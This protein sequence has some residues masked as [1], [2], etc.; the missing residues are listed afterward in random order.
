MTE[1]PSNTNAEQA[2]LLLTAVE[3][4]GFRG[5]RN[6]ELRGLE[7]INFLVGTG[8]SGKTS[9]LEA[10]AC[11]SHPL[12]VRE[13][14]RTS[15][16]REARENRFFATHAIDALRWM[17][18]HEISTDGDE[19]YGD[20]SVVI[21]GAS[22]IK[23]LRAHCEPYSGLRRAEAMTGIDYE[24][25]AELANASVVEDDGWHFKLESLLRGANSWES[26]ELVAWSAG[27]TTLPQATGST[28]NCQLIAP[29]AHR[30]Q[31]AQ[32]RAL[33]DV[34]VNDQKLAVA[35]LLHDLDPNIVGIEIISEGSSGRAQLALRHKHSGIAP[36]HV[37]GDGLRRALMIA[38]A[39][40]QCR[41]GVMLIDEIEAALH[42]SALGKVFP[43]LERACIEHDVQLI[44]TTHSLE[45]IDAVAGSIDND[46]V[47]AFHI[48]GHLGNAKRYSKDMLRRLVHERGLDIR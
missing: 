31:P 28:L 29:Y 30:N 21:E 47:A 17:F 34:T 6:L 1:S 38:L 26:L 46:H 44:G 14:L 42:V 32:L 9:V 11:Y 33:T 24:D 2:P 16:F 43:W 8:N 48:D 22:P 35:E 10:I 36:L 23:A 45:A 20:I 25:E 15:R 5:V 39:V 3:I 12:D 19:L 4:G 37:F 27:T 7:R 13:W 41:K 40:V 18:P